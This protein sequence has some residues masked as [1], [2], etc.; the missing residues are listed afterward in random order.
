MNVKFVIAMSVI[1]AAARLG[2]SDS[3][4]TA[5]ATQPATPPATQPTIPV[6][7]P[8]AATGPSI[9]GPVLSAD[10]APSASVPAPTNLK[11]VTVTSQEMVE[12][13]APALGARTYT[14][15]LDRIQNVPGGENAAGQQVLLRAPGVVEDS[16]GQLHVRG[17]H[18]NVT[19]RVNGVLLPQPVASFG[20][21]LDTHLVQ[22]MT[23]IDGSL[24]A[25]FGFHT[26]GIIDVTTKTGAN[27]NGGVLSL[28]GGSHDTIIPSLQLGGTQDRFS[29]FVTGTYNHNGLGIE[30]PTN[31][32]RAI[33]DYTDQQKYFGY[34]S[35]ELD[36]TSRVSLFMNVSNADFQIPNTPGLVPGFDLAD[37][38]FNDSSKLNETQNEQ[39]YYIV[40]A[41]QKV[42]G[43]FSFQLAGFS[44]YGTIDFTP[45]HQGDLVFQG[46]AGNVYNGFLTNG[47]QFDSSYVI[48]DQHTL[49]AGVIAD[50]TNE[51]LNTNTAVFAVDPNTGNQ[52]SN[53]P[54]TV[55]DDTNNR[56]LE[57]GI[58]VQDEWH[59][60]PQLT[61]NYGLRYDRFDAN[62]DDEGQLSPRA[63]LVWNIDENTTAH[64]GY[65]RYFVPPP[66]Q[67][68]RLASIEKFAGTT[69][70]PEV[71]QADAPKVERSDYLDLGISRQIM[72]AWQVGLDGFYKRAH[73]LVDEGQF[74]APVI[75]SPFNYRTGTVEGAELSSTYKQGGW[76]LFGN[77][78]WVL[79]SASD[80]D[81]QQFLI[82]ADEL[83]YIKDNN[84]HLDHQGEYTASAGASY[85][86]KNDRVYVD[87]LYGSGLRNG[88][89]NT[90]HLPAYYP[91]S[92]GW[93][94]IFHL[95]DTAR[96]TVHLR[97]DIV[98]LFDEKYEL[99]DGSGIGVGAAQWGA[100]RG[101]FGGISYNF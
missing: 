69:N 22:S 68:T 36:D 45:D 28:Y 61:L 59:I 83:A 41:Y 13:I 72:P 79:T 31:S 34:F 38:T 82:G 35:F 91:V 49:R 16:F 51:A 44:R 98:N 8:A 99:R 18:A 5:P 12:Q 93:E 76:S 56:A 87:F 63:N 62:F 27:L 78:S 19:Y 52:A 3:P 88:F 1:A 97:F 95:D 14:L 84:I 67:N 39:E 20:Q 75:L 32:A 29:Y 48:N 77:F 23:L 73:Q 70:S 46:V 96:N 2:F 9:T 55:V 81:T 65:A 30:N 66:I 90:T 86:W 21:E 89:A 71:F 4:T 6:M 50:Y 17:E 43:D 40:M 100:R 42:V 24:P 7:K 11:K 58:Y 92:V 47:V 60:V 15:G 80:I 85:S 74:G 33:H 94:H 57:A 37:S 26:A 10:V 64:G 101:F 53:V 25:Q 54:F